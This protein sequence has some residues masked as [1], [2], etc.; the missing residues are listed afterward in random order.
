MDRGGPGR[1][2]PDR[3]EV[4]NEGCETPARPPPLSTAATASQSRLFCRLCFVCWLCCHLLRGRLDE[5]EDRVGAG[6]AGLPRLRVFSVLGREARATSLAP[7]QAEGFGLAV[8]SHSCRGFLRT[9]CTHLP[10]QAVE[11]T[12]ALPARLFLTRNGFPQMRH[13]RSIISRAPRHAI[14]Y[15]PWLLIDNMERHRSGLGGG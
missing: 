7:Q 13:V 3:R 14:R 6:R 2:A 11:Q 12:F 15:C 9:R 10:P 4:S 1:R 8:A 5:C